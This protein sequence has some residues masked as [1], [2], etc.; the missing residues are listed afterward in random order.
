M[1]VD[2]GEVIPNRADTENV[3]E[4]GSAFKN[5]VHTEALRRSPSASLEQVSP[6]CSGVF[7]P[8]STLTAGVYGGCEG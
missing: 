7:G 5:T 8:G 6:I 3:E 4:S 2:V 1:A